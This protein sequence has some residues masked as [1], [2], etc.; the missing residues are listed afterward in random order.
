MKTEKQLARAYSEL[1]QRLTGKRFLTASGLTRKEAAALLNREA[2]LEKL[3]RVLPIRQRVLCADVLEL[4]RPEM[5]RLA[6]PEQPEKGWL[7]YIYGTASRILYPELGPRPEDG[8]CHAA[9]LFYLEVLR[10]VLDYERE[11][12]PFDPAYDFDFPSQEEISGCTQAEEYRTFLEDWREQHI[13]QLLRLGNEATPFSTLSHIAGV[14]YV[15]MAAARGLAAAGVP[16]DLALVSGAAAGHDLGK[17]GCKP[18]E[19]VPYLHYFYTDQWFTRMG[20]PVISHIAANHSTWDLEPENLT[21]ESLLLI[22]A[23]FRSKQ[24]RGPDGREVTRIYGLDDSFQIILSKLDNVDAKKLRRYQF[25]Y[26]RL[27]DFEDYMRSLGVDVDLTGH[28]APVKELPSVVL[29][30]VDDTIQSLVFLGIRHNLDVMHTLADERGFGN[31]LEAA[32]SEKDWK[33]IRAYL[34]IFREYSTYLSGA[35]KSQLLDFLYELLCHREGDI[36]RYAADL[37]ASP[38]AWATA[39]PLPCWTPCMTCRWTAAPTKRSR[40]W[41]SLPPSI[42]CG[43]RC[44]CA[45]RRPAF[46]RC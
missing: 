43:T 15:A 38:A 5:E 18:G 8:R 13:Y 16:V 35:Q 45:F 34:D 26:A 37:T 20:L 11:A 25:V 36:R 3:G 31:I 17:Y 28:P 2:W 40:C 12:L 46:S 42:S 22:Y 24:E 6:G 39:E 10:L 4:C 27:H 7:V 21:V 33:N 14:H 32:R 30:S 9:A 23:D 19:R 44:P 1:A 29:R 41:W